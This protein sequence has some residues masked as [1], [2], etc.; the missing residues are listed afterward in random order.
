MLNA[1]IS[2]V[3]EV[4]LI[5]IQCIPDPQGPCQAQFVSDHMQEAAAGSTKL[6]AVSKCVLQILEVCII[7]TA[8]LAVITRAEKATLY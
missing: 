3:E 5:I 1:K 8:M 6:D 2:V 4:N 7:S